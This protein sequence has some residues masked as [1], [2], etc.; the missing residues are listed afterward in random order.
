LRL[1]LDELQ[2]KN[3]NDEVFEINGVT[4]VIDKYTHKKVGTININFETKE[5]MSGFVVTGNSSSC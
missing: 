3:K 4:Y 1:T 2:D 5:G